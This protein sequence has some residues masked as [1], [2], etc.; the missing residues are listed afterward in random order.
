M[1]L[2]CTSAYYHSHTDLPLHRKLT[3]FIFRVLTHQLQV[4]VSS[5]SSVET[6]DTSIQILDNF[7]AQL[8]FQTRCEPLSHTDTSIISLAAASAVILSTKLHEIRPLCTVSADFDPTSRL[9]SSTTHLHDLTK[10]HRN[11][12]IM[13]IASIWRNFSNDVSLFPTT[14]S[15][16]PHFKKEKLVDFERRLLLKIGFHIIPQ[17]TP[18]AFVRHMLELWPPNAE[19]ISHHDVLSMADILIG[20]FWTGKTTLKQKNCHASHTFDQYEW[21]VHKPL[22]SYSNVSQHRSGVAMLQLINNSNISSPSNIFKVAFE[23]PRMAPL[24]PWWM[25]SPENNSVLKQ[26]STIPWSSSNF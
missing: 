6:R 11:A 1:D 19:A 24:S 13:I 23:L 12:L 17:A 15:N 4:M 8:D 16:F 5:S 22:T 20:L 26:F 7:L 18:S 21:I 2:E 3:N 9:S 25:P 14:Q 10:F